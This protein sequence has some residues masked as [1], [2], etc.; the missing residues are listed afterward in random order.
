MQ[1]ARDH[2]VTDWRFPE[3]GLTT[4]EEFGSGYPAGISYPIGCTSVDVV[5]IDPDTKKWLASNIDPV[6]GFP[7]VV[8]FSWSTAVNILSSDALPVQWL[9][10]P[11]SL[12]YCD[13]LYFVGRMMMMMGLLQGVL[14]LHNFSLQKVQQLNEV[15]TNIFAN[16]V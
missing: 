12:M 7:S 1:V 14:K 6:F 10:C 13:S 5:L 9:V 3:Q 15:N 16:A 8:R 11:H 2:V 4:Q